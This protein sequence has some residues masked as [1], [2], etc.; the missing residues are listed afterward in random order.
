MQTTHRTP[1][2]PG[3]PIGPSDVAA[4]RHQT[5]QRQEVSFVQ[6]A[7]NEAVAL[8][9]KNR[10]RLPRSL[11]PTPGIHISYDVSNQSTPFTDASDV[12]TEAATDDDKSETEVTRAWS[13]S[14]VGDLD[15]E[16][17][18]QQPI[19]KIDSS[20]LEIMQMFSDFLEM[21]FRTPEARANLAYRKSV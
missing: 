12:R 19:I 5:V 13:D 20:G 3:Q 11:E 8:L 7:Y 10:T 14:G 6:Q 2:L 17:V 9:N 21:H 16:L 4:I 18:Q 15:L 1:L